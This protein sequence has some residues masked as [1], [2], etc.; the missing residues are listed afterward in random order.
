MNKLWNFNRFKFVNDNIIKEYSEFNQYQ[1]DIGPQNPLGPGFGFATDPSL[2]IYGSDS[3]SPYVDYYSRT[4]GSVSRLNQITKAAM[5]DIE[6][7][8]A[9]SKQDNFLE[10][11]ENFSDYKILRIFK[12]DSLHLN[13][14]ISF[15]F[16]EEEFFGV[17]KD[18]NWFSE[19]KLKSE[20]F[21]DSR[22]SYMDMEYR[23]KLSAFMKNILDKW[24]RPNKDFY[25][26]LKENCPVKTEM[27]GIKHLKKNS[28]VE[29]KGVDMEKDGTPYIIMKQNNKKYYLKNN[30]YFF[31]NYWFE[32]LEK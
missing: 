17:F 6:Q 24:F 5:S 21:T 16:N 31:F 2:S 10:D 29:I 7:S 8:I 22:F 27:G 19:T 3:D 13:I 28:V 9:I 26:N 1:M 32:P 30:D 12:N 14:F 18:F 15:N 11:I 4:A 20:M 23:L 25:T